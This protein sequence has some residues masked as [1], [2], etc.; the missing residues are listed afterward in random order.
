MATGTT[1]E[2]MI[3]VVTP[4]AG[5]SVTEGTILEWHVKVG[6]SIELDATIV[7]ISTD[8][9]DV[10]LPAPA[11]GVVTEL[12]V[13]EGDT[14]TVGQVIA[15]IAVGAD[16]PASASE[17]NGSGSP[18]TESA[19]EPEAEA[20]DTAD[21][22]GG[23]SD[24]ANGSG[25]GNATTA[26]AGAS[27]TP[28]ASDGGAA[29]GQLVDVVTPAAGES[30]TEGT[31]LEWRVKPG[32]F[33]KADAT[34]VEISTDKVDV[35]LPA[36]ASGEV[37]ELLVQEGD[38][39]TVGQVIAR[40]AVGAADDRAASPTA[41]GGGSANAPPTEGGAPG[42]GALPEGTKVSPVA[43]RAAAAE[44][45][46]LSGV[47]GSG[48]AG[49]IVKSDVLTAAGGNGA[50]ASPSPT[51][52]GAPA[53][54][55]AETKPMRAGAAALARY[56]EQSRSI[57]TATSFRTLAVTMLEARRRELKAAERKVSFTHLI[58]YAIA[59]AAD[60]MPVMADHFAEIDGKPNRVHDGQ[61]NLGL[62]VD[63]EKKDGSRTLMVPV[64]RDAG[65]MPF[66]RFVAAYDALVEKARTNT[67]TAD[68]LQGANVTL[69][70]PGGIGT[71]ASVPRLMTG[72][73]TIVATGSIAYPPGL[74]NIGQM[75]GA[76]KVMTMT[77]T[78]DHRI[79]Q[80]AESGRFLA[81]VEE[82]LVGD[83][84]F[85][86]GVFASLGVEL[87]SAPQP[88]APAAAAAAATAAAASASASSGDGTG[89]TAVSEDLLRAVQAASTLVSRYR[90]HGHLAAMLDPLDSEPEGDP[91]LDPKPLG[92]TPE[93]QARIPAKVL[94]MYVPGATLADAL[95]HLRETYCGTIAYEIEHI[96]SHRQ[97]V[98]LREHIESGAFRNPL[99]NDESR[100]LL[101]RLVKVDA[102]ERFMHK[103]YL[104]QHQFSIEGLDMTV[105]IVDELIKLSAAHG[106]KEVVIGMAHRGRLNVLAHNLGRAYE[107]IF[108]EFEGASTLEA[109]TTIPQGGTGDVKYHHGTQGSYDL[110]DGET[111]RVNLE[112]NPS[113]LEYVYPVVEGA[114][115]AAQ[116]TRQGPHAH[117]DTD[118][119]V[120]IVI[121]GDASFPAQGVVSETLNLQALDGYKVGGTV[122]I[123][124]NNQ[125]GFTTDPD[126]ARS[127]RWASDLAKGF[128]VP[129]VHVNADDVQACMSAV[130]L[131]FAFRQEFGH[132]VLID[133]IGYR[134]F[135][136]NESDEPA[137][138]QPEMYAKIKTK[139]R[140]S[141]L[142][143]DRLVAEGVVTKEEV[144]S[145]AQEVW[146]HLTLLHQRLK[147]KIAAAAEHDGEHATGE[148]ELDRSPSPE[149]ETA[150]PAA[151]LREIG[152]ELLSVPEGF[153]VHPKLV[154]QLERR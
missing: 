5:E 128:D 130:R 78:Y 21:D 97:R 126:D 22:G 69:T 99:T 20:S 24:T 13:A 104:G 125:V 52:D 149:V 37:A 153:T 59:R 118:A 39:V 29:S 53:A 134:R 112:S 92:L 3:D 66:E 50:A 71:I 131:A 102:L 107:T 58:A 100:W 4:A 103:A 26:E 47:S 61:V 152:E 113:H 45:V 119:A 115:R 28:S 49:R 48:P 18:T 90:S 127:T 38:T 2:Q 116:T 148:Y 84:G 65:R 25:A 117:Q 11:S 147:A 27:A 57:P 63:V 77:S 19:T 33:I 154:K 142:W 79:I 91:G 60:D 95:P 44:G 106:G 150:V 80:G 88:P 30:V 9:V 139:K 86:E 135:G 140:V 129:I 1:A 7:E 64:I 120:P 70:N 14:V 74:A 110:G 10:E 89:A 72:Q 82:Y 43:A 73:G 40:I 124:T 56:M 108:A 23:A 46:D 8:K 85:Y 137:Y 81:R 83:R 76:E 144:D 34:I 54:A 87:G 145:Q 68:D 109:V 98:W 12:L 105:P 62:A 36:P 15:R 93:I 75:I 35:E 6:E 96:A 138:T 133:L 123:I 42:P 141:E 146:D 94:N 111:I 122:H 17:G 121:H 132:D 151:R 114:T 32:E 16:A 55:Q 31:I 101:R 136:H 41:G 143:A 67:L 51:A